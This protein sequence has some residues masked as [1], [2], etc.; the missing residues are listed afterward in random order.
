MKYR[1]LALLTAACLSL[2]GSALAYAQNTDQT[3]ETGTEQKPDESQE[4]NTD[5]SEIREVLAFGADLSAEQK[6]TVMAAF[7]L[8]E[9][10][11]SGMDVITVTNA[12]EHEYLDSYLSSSVIGS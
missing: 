9:A 11:L 4:Q 3:M 7:G 10:S 5:E 6:K 1:M 8:D 12:E 2:Y